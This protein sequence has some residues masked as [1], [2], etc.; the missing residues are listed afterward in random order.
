MPAE[1]DPR[2]T[3]LRRYRR[4]RER[5]QREAARQK[6]NAPEPF[7]GGRPRAG[8]FLVLVI[9]VLAALAWLQTRR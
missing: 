9:V 4:D 6:P 1:R 2:V 5:A 7:L 3:D 8:L